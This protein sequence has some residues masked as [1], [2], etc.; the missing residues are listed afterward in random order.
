MG[1][2]EW[3]GKAP[4]LIRDLAGP[5]TAVGTAGGGFVMWMMMGGFQPWGD[6][7]GLARKMYPDLRGDPMALCEGPKISP[8]PSQG[9]EAAVCA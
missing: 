4:F 6:R 8:C 5:S 2:L 1:R 7:A 3:D 9:A